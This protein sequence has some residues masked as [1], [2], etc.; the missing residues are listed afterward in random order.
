MRAI[1]YRP[2]ALGQSPCEI[3]WRDT[4]EALITPQH[5]LDAYPQRLLDRLIDG[6]AEHPE[7]TLIAERGRDGQWIEVSYTDML[8]RVR[9]I[10]QA[11]HAR[12][13]SAERPIVI[14]SGNSIAHLALAFGAMWAGIPHCPLSPAASLRSRDC[15]KVRHAMALLTPGLVFADDLDAFAAAIEATVPADVEIVGISGALANREATAFEQLQSTPAS[16]DIDAVHAATG[17]DTIAK[18][19]FTSGSTSLPKAVTTTQRMLCANQQMLVQTFPFLAEEPPVL[20]DWLP[21]NHTFGGSH[22]VGIALYNGG[23]LYID[24]GRPTPELFAETV[25]N[26]KDI[27]PTLYLNV[28][29]GWEELSHALEQDPALRHSFYKRLKL[30][31]FAAAGLSQTTWDRLDALA[32][33]ACGERIRVMAGLGATETAP[34]SMFTTVP[35]IRSGAVGLPCPGCILK[36]VPTG[37]GYE[38]RFSGPHVMPGYWRDSDKTAA[39]FDDDGFYCSGDAIDFID[40][41][42]L[43]AG[44]MFDGRIAENFKLSSGSFVNSAA[45]RSRILERGKPW[46]QDVVITGVDR[47]DIGA[48]VI[49]DIGECR[50]RLG[51]D[52]TATLAELL[53][54]DRLT[55]MFADILVD[56]NTVATGSASRIARACV[57]AEPPDFDAGEI[58]DKGSINQRRMRTTRAALIERLYAG[59][60]PH[61]ITIDG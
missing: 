8:A 21:W 43:A 57:L 59:K 56:V 25:R 46:V 13:L 45:L 51:A 58:T 18:F 24:A 32:E 37:E 9:S 54:G 55:P 34:S 12:G 22:N 29:R 23:S 19:L 5:E 26:L 61:C 14:L 50:E 40:P 53:A 35:G 60:A 3:A 7:R 33:T 49:P 4:G 39:V 6:A 41:S 52:R 1:R 38:A 16:A 15:G 47:G 20:V 11:L 17:P 36:L 42:N 10:A 28:P 48:L 2:V 30:Q 31:F 44:F 27:S